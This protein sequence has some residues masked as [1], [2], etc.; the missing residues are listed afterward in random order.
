V[1]GCDIDHMTEF[2]GKN[3]L[4]T[5]GGSGIG[6]AVARKL[7][8][9]GAQVAIAGRNPERLES[10]AKSLEAGD[11]ALAVPA[12]VTQLADLDRLYREIKDH[13]GE[14]HGVVANAGVGQLAR[15]ADVTE[16][17]F[18][19]VVDTNFKGTFF[20]IQK[21]I[22]MLA[23]GSS[24]VITGSWT[25]HR[26]MALGS[27]YS[28]SKAAAL[29]LTGA[30]AA[31][32]ADRGIRVNSV[33]PGHIGT[34]MF[35]GVTGGSNQVREMFRSQ[36]ALGTIGQPDEVAETVLFLLSQ[37]ASYTTGQD[38]VVDGGLLGSVPL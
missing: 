3:I 34:D 1:S 6:L 5:G 24:V 23:D 8:A 32:L 19:R 12:D 22:P 35:D 9:A 13:F 26:G 25:V 10:A 18:D 4:I 21:A 15:A 28:A 17:D 14:L 37:R 7:T 11:R 27:V 30:L 31:D 20:T 2:A 36:V 29:A 16:D 33:T 38:I